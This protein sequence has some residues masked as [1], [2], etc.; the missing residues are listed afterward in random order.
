MREKHHQHRLWRRPRGQIF[1][2]VVTVVVAL[3]LSLLDIVPAQASPSC[4]GSA[5]ALTDFVL[6]FT[7]N[8]SSF[9]L[10]LPAQ[11]FRGQVDWGDGG[12]DFPDY[13]ASSATPSHAYSS[14]TVGQ[15]FYVCLT[16][17]AT[18]F[19]SPEN[20]SS[21]SYNP[22]N[23]H[24][25]GQEQL[26][27]VTQWGS[28]EEPGGSTTFISLGAAFNGATRLCAVADYMTDDVIDMMY[29]FQD[30][31]SLGNGCAVNFSHWDT[32]HVLSMHR[33]FSGA[34]YFNGDVSSWD[35]SSVN[36]MSGM[37]SGNAYFNSDIS[38]WNTS[39]VID[40]SFMFHNATVF[41]QPINFVPASGGTPSKWDT[42]HVENMDGMFKGAA[43]FDQDLNNWDTSS[44]R[45]MSEMFL[46]AT[47]FGRS[48]GNVSAWDTSEVGSAFWSSGMDGM[49]AL[50]EN[51]NSN[52]SNWDTSNV[53]DMTGMFAGATRFN[54]NISYV[55][56]S[57]GTPSKW[58][59]SNVTHMTGMFSD[60][61]AFNGDI[62]NWHTDNLEDSAIMFQRATNFNRN[63][64]SVNGAWNMSNVGNVQSM[65]AW[66][67]SFNGDI[68]DWDISSVMNMSNMFRGATSFNQD[69]GNWDTGLVLNMAS[70]FR[71]ASVFNQ[72]LSG[73]ET[74]EVRHMEEMFMNATAFNGDISTWDVRHVSNMSSMFDSAVSFNQ[75]ISGWQTLELAECEYMFSG[76]ATFNQNLSGWTMTGVTDMES[77]FEGATAFNGDV[78]TWD[79]S[80]V[81]WMGWMFNNA[82]SFNQDLSAWNIGA[83]TAADWM[84]SGTSLST[85]NYSKLLRSWAT[86]PHQSGTAQN[87]IVLAVNTVQYNGYDTDY[88]NTV[89]ADRQ[90]LIDNHWDIFDGG[91]TPAQSSSIVAI[92]STTSITVG[93][94]VSASILSGGMGMP[95]GT[96]T[97]A[98]PSAV[99]PV[100]PQS[101]LVDFTPDDDIAYL[102][103]TVTVTLLVASA[104]APTPTPTSSATGLSTTGIHSGS[105][106]W[107]GTVAAGLMLLG[108]VLR[109]WSSRRKHNTGVG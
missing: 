80:N 72:D 2:W 4:G 90:A 31:S 66:A 18:A 42:G 26:T 47:E 105:I 35:V 21:P 81:D 49:F 64:N 46:G 71:E 50:A 55:P 29:M 44:V 97:F 92:P 95:Y 5:P 61:T 86:Q 76:A 96:F 23:F 68:S 106:E 93:Q 39:A 36:W 67:S 6:E 10:D 8:T 89:E 28:L 24:W 88:Y 16:G 15:P 19:G 40:M 74:T 22:W 60:A 57:G 84:L 59:T 53:K 91:P 94:P 58:D 65:F 1:S 98:N 54:R 70:M 41:N 82:S 79:V 17:F 52:I 37:Y 13:S 100:G 11:H 25:A 103:T 85:L 101:V 56:A 107:G 77:M 34:T 83:V 7:P 12:V 48:L 43:I 14:L 102:P 51:F 32:S 63:I 33:M 78:T 9:T 69:I 87:P 62:S 27:A 109:F 30:A 3:V 20:P 108:G 38:S 99:L 75:N 73:W 104:P 45:E